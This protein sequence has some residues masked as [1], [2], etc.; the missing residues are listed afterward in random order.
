MPGLD[1]AVEFRVAELVWQRVLEVQQPIWHGVISPLDA[2]RPQM[3]RSISSNGW[4]ESLPA[5]LTEFV[6]IRIC[7]STFGTQQHRLLIHLITGARLFAVWSIDT[8]Q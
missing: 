7:C 6:A 2:A 8:H 5:L 4:R 3:R 1:D